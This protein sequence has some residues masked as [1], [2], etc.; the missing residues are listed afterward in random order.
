MTVEFDTEPKGEFD[1]WQ[2]QRHVMEELAAN[3]G[4]MNVAYRA[5]IAPRRRDT[6]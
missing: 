6:A 4:L 5:R 1:N 2:Y 3:A